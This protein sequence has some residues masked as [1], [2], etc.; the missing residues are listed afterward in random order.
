MSDLLIATHASST[1][2][3]LKLGS[4]FTSEIEEG[5]NI[6]ETIRKLN[7]RFNK[8][9]L[10]VIPLKFSDQ[11]VLVYLY[12]PEQL[13]KELENESIYS[14]LKRYGYTSKDEVRAVSHLASRMKRDEFPHEVGVFLGYPLEDVIGFIEHKEDS[15]LVG[16]WRVY[17]DVDQAKKKF[18][19]YKKCTR[20]FISNLNRKISLEDMIIATGGN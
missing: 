10:R 13:Q 12:R 17:G 9:G 18:E 8:K 19:M 2:A 7:K 20:Q 6:Y 4:L 11:K 1:L 14:F 16:Y 3:N 5:E 15:K